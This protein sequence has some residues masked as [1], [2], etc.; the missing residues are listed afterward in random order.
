[1]KRTYSL[2]QQYI[3]YA[4]L[5]SFFLQSCGGFNN[6]IPIQ[7]EPT[8]PVQTA[9][10]AIS[11]QPNSNPLIGQELTAQG[12]HM[13]T[14]YQEN[15]KLKADV[16]MNVLQGF[17]KSYEGLNVYIEQGAELANLFYLDKRVQKRRIH[18]ELAKSKQP[19]RIVIYK[20]SGLMGGML[21]GEEEAEEDELENES[22]PNEC[23]CPITQEIMEDPVIAQDGHTYERKAIKRWLDM[24]KRTSPKTGARLL[25]T[26]FVPNY[27]M[28]S[29][30]QDLKAQIPVLARHKVDMRTIET[31][32][33]LRE[34]EIE[35]ALEQKGQLVEKESQTR[36]SLEKELEKK[37]KELEEKTVLLSIMEKRVKALEADKVEAIS[38]KGPSF[39]PQ[40]LSEININNL[41]SRV[42][43]GNYKA[44]IE[45]LDLSKN[46]HADVQF[47][48]GVMYYTGDGV[49]KDEVKAV[50]WFQKAADQGYPKAQYNLGLMYETGWIVMQDYYQAFKW[51]RKAAGKGYLLAQ[52]NLG[53]MYLNGQGITKDYAKAKKWYKKVAKQGL[54]D[55]QYE[56][57][58]LYCYGKNVKKDYG[59][60][61]RWLEKAAEQYHTE[62][63]N[64]LY[65]LIFLYHFGKRCVNFNIRQRW[66][67]SANQ[68]DLKAYNALESMHER[69]FIEEVDA[70]LSSKFKDEID[71]EFLNLINEAQ[72]VAEK[73]R[74][75]QQNTR[76]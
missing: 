1:M 45:L 67:E 68:G 28:R 48:L 11:P 36:L 27:S 31:A 15:G 57:G 19:S 25:S 26:E 60:A 6:L 5:I 64:S 30:I 61:R 59:K 10:Q 65:N 33:K 41:A 16:A 55:A 54:A 49:E 17:S 42:K 58:L 62:A 56:L 38:S 20:G 24:G 63:Q 3:A 75:N 66:E 53:R 4:L 22:I 13:V 73:F 74:I 52:Y 12:G 34:Q 51:F 76:C 39:F 9:A 21:E 8:A 35:E 23:F 46:H 40:V 50:E 29:L 43:E 32:V 71:E 37:E 7:D 14:C 44:L 47:N 18:V 72:A 2:F 70:L 69:E